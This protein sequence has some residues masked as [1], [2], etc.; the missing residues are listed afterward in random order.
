MQISTNSSKSNL[1]IENAPHIRAAMSTQSI[2]LIVL[3]SLIPAYCVVTYYFGFATL[4]QFCISAL[5]GFIIEIIIALMRE[6]KA[7]Y[8][9]SD[10]S[11]LVTSALL[12]LA[13]PSLI[14]YYLTISS[15]AFAI[16]V[17]K[18]VFGGLGMNIFNPAMA[19]F[20][21]LVIS[22]PQA[23][24]H[25]YVSPAPNAMSVLTINKAVDIVIKQQPSDS[26][27]NE[28]YALNTK[29]DAY[30]GATFL[31]TIK[32]QRKVHAGQ[33]PTEVNFTNSAYKAYLLVSIAY[34]FGGL[35][36]FGFKIIQISMP[37]TFI[38]TILIG[39][40]IWNKFMPD[41]SITGVEHLL[42]GG[43]ALCAFYIIT[44][45]VTNSGTL[46]G[47]IFF[48]FFTAMLVLLIRVHGS[49]SD[50]VAFAT[51]LANI[52]APLIDVI[53]KRRAFGIGYKKG[54]LQ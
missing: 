53:T 48:S 37:I 4:L 30:S 39:G 29:V 13:L 51:L 52:A 45:P 49:Y 23:F 6:R 24:Y 26:V 35:I 19:G 8:Y 2:M 33:Y 10:L 20:I 34:L 3:L 17:V 14:P 27:Q 12:A 38:L 28:I 21:F 11:F 16:V 44:D 54:G 32:T 42:F 31:E 36:L 47:R 43:T 25:N 50:S 7:F 46:K 9:V 1:G 41:V 22:T 15:T 18:Q 5:T 40:S